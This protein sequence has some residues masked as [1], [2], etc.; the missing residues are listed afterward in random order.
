MAR[1]NKAIGALV[2]AGVAGSTAGVALGQEVVGA[3]NGVINVSGATLLNNFVSAQ[4]STR[5]FIDVD[6]DFLAG[7]LGT[8]PEQLAPANIQPAPGDQWGVMYRSVGSINGFIELQQFGITFL[9]DRAPVDD[10]LGTQA[11]LTNLIT[12]PVPL[13]RYNRTAIIN[14]SARQGAAGFNPFNAGGSPVRVNTDPAS[15]NYLKGIWTPTS[16]ASNSLNSPGYTAARIFLDPATGSP[17]RGGVRIDAAVLDVP[18][19]WAVRDVDASPVSPTKTPVSD[20]YGHNSRVAVDKAGNNLSG[21]NA[22]NQ[23][24]SVGAYNFTNHDAFTLY[25]TPFAWAPIAPMANYGTGLSQITTTNLRHGFVSGRLRSGENLTFVTR[26]VGS[27]TRNAWNNTTGTDP[28]YGV[29]EN[30]G[31]R[32]GNANT[33]DQLGPNYLPSNKSSNSNVENT[34]RNTRLAIGY[35]GVELGANTGWLTRPDGTRQADFLLVQNNL[36][37]GTTFVRANAST[38]VHNGP[39]GWRIGGPAS[40]VTIGDP[41]SAPSSLGGSG[42]LEGWPRYNWDRDPRDP[43]VKGPRPA[44][45]GINSNPDMRNPQAAAYVN[46][47]S[48]SVAAASQGLTDNLAGSPGELLAFSFAL[49]SSLD[50]VPS[51]LNPSQFVTNTPSLPLQNDIINNSIFSASVNPAYGYFDATSRGW[52]PQRENVGTYADGTNGTTGYTNEDGSAL[53]ETGNL[54]LRNKIFFDFNGDG[55]RNLNG[56]S[57]GTTDITE[58]MKAWRQRATGGTF[59]W[60]PVNGADANMDILG[61]ANGDGNFNAA[62]IRY[63]ADGLAVVTGT[64]DAESETDRLDRKAGFIAVDNA[65]T[66][67]FGVALGTGFF[68]TTL[69]HGAYDAGD[70]R[71]DVKGAATKTTRGFAPVGADGVVNAADIDYVYAQFMT[72]PAVT[73]GAATWTDTNEAAFFD[74]S[75]DMTGDLVVDQQDIAEILSILE[76]SIGDVNLDGAT[77]DADCVIATANL[78][79]TGLGWAGGDVD[80]DG[81]V[82]SSDLALICPPAC[83]PDVNQDGNVDQDD[84]SYLINVVGGGDNPTG[85]DPD[86]NQDGNVDQDD[87]SSL[88]NTVGGGG[89]P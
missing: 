6:G 57:A 66:G 5:D 7:A 10:T 70:A 30:V 11:P 19:A 39:E 81:T 61:D 54:N 74:L 69:A 75:A 77:D 43:G 87:I 8:S 26:D 76:T 60:T 62:D 73:D 89:C 38:V 51:N 71:A 78:G 1:R 22:T 36:S 18:G 12:N 20:G 32:N 46:N 48:R 16:E 88:I 49:T 14:N 64:A 63:F 80:G 35:A 53:S 42:D 47:I 68:N 37:G 72:N 85:I 2:L 55:A 52:V 50:F 65:Y 56:V 13:A 3:P 41:R 21:S 28:A 17:A 44:A 29:G 45:E 40:F 15:P 34:V 84:V 59:N 67:V 27:G 82:T 4:S 9:T 33:F 58:A 83:D 79:L 25:D 23:L 31:L 86:F 24:P